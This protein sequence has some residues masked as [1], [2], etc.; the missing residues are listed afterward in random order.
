MHDM[1]FKA[2]HE[3][4]RCGNHINYRPKKVG[5]TENTQVPL[6][7][8]LHTS[9]SA[10]D[11]QLENNDSKIH[12]LKCCKSVKFTQS[13]LFGGALMQAGQRKLSK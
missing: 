13:K 2:T 7:K 3:E 6:F 10:P 8:L 11:L 4:Y 5:W 12:T 9:E 1:M